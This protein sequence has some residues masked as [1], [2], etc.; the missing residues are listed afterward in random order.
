MIYLYQNPITLEI[1][2]VTQTMRELHQFIDDHGLE[3][4]RVWTRP[5]MSVDSKIDPNNAA[6]FV[7]YTKNRGGTLGDLTELSGE[8]AKARKDKYGYDHVEE[9]SYKK[10]F[11]ERKKLHP[12]QKKELFKESFKNNK[13]FDITI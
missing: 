4:K 5:A 11:K 8:L 12:K 10:Y 6:D 2:E 3:W 7:K 9:A 13:N 1:K